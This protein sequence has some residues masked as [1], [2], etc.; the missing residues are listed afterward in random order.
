MKEVVAY[1]IPDFSRINFYLLI[2]SS[3]NKTVPFL[4]DML[5]DWNTCQNCNLCQY[6]VD[7]NAILCRELYYRN[8][9]EYS[10]AG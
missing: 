4:Q 10:Y 1:S 6:A 2:L 9:R 8:V 5:T 3:R 7:S